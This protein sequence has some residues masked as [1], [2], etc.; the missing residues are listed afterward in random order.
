M[1]IWAECTASGVMRCRKETLDSFTPQMNPSV[2]YYSEITGM[3]P[4][5][6]SGWTHNKTEGTWSQPAAPEPEP[7]PEPD[8]EYWIYTAVSAD[9]EELV[10][11]GSTSAQIDIQLY[12]DA[13][14]T[15]KPTLPAEM[16]RIITVRSDMG[17][18]DKN[19]IVDKFAVTFDTT[20]AASVAYVVPDAAQPGLFYVD[21][22]DLR[23]VAMPDGNEYRFKL[24][25]QSGQ[26]RIQIEVY[27]VP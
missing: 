16:Q 14:L 18:G 4:M 3:N 22:G 20:G 19:P 5:P 23:P 24:V 17:L 27:R 7:T 6:K 15:V 26:D 1:K 12:L 10:K 13:D 11:D 21:E 9:K 25:S 2:G 8:P